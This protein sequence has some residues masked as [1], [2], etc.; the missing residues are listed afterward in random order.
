[1]YIF[2]FS[3]LEVKSGIHWKVSV[4]KFQVNISNFRTPQ[5]VAT[6]RISKCRGGETP[7]IK[8]ITKQ[9][10]EE[11]LRDPMHLRKTFCLHRLF[12]S[13]Q[14]VPRNGTAKHNV[15][16]KKWYK[17]ILLL[18]NSVYAVDC[19]ITL[20]DMTYRDKL[21]GLSFLSLG[22]D[23]RMVYTVHSF[24]PLCCAGNHH[25][26]HHWLDLLPHTLLHQ[27]GNL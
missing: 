14:R 6:S 1:M 10:T 13:T 4:I 2:S 8:K 12:I 24:C 25:T 18:Q 3:S 11:H 17:I 22:L 19:D 20:D 15:Q 27:S 7:Y 23:R 5:V 26:R 9:E 16:I 21:L